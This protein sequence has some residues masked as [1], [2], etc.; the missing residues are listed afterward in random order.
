MI[1]LDKLKELMQRRCGI[2]PL[3]WFWLPAFFLI[4]S[5]LLEL[6]AGEEILN[7]LY[8]ERGPFEIIQFLICAVCFVLGLALMLKT[9]I[10]HHPWLFLWAFIATLGSFYVAGEEIS[11]GQHFIHWDTPEKW[12]A[13]NDQKETNLHN[14]SSW[15]DQKP[16]T[17]LEFGIII[18]GFIIPLLMMYKPQIVPQRF[19]IIYPSVIFIPLAIMTEIP[20]AIDKL[21]FKMNGEEFTLLHR[22]SEFHELYMFYFIFVYLLLMNRRINRLNAD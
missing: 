21:F 2:P 20:R 3:L 10:H 9:N 15:F 19:K 8:L 22:G 11:W 13:L 16:R 12:L 5:I 18:G 7:T 17:L 6:A 1:A 14:T 4:G